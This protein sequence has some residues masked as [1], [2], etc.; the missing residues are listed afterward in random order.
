MVPQIC[1]NGKTIRWSVFAVDFYVTR[2]YDAQ[3]PEE[4]LHGRD[5]V[6][7]DPLMLRPVTAYDVPPPGPKKKRR[8]R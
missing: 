1:R 3:W 4:T 6:D 5:V 2:L 8:R 7:N